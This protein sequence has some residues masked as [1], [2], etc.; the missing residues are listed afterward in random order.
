MEMRTINP[1]T[2]RM[3]ELVERGTEFHG[4]LGPFLISGLRMGLLALRE[5]TSKGHFDLRAVIETGTVPPLSCMIDGVQVATGCTL[6]K[7]NIEVLD[8]GRARA[9]FSRGEKYLVVE[10]RPELVGRFR[11]GEAEAL[12]REA[13][14]MSDGELLKWEL[15]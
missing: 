7:G 12:A 1:G 3:E 15:Q 9:T 5:L 4:H 10:L 14:K 8:L 11:E 2:V 13:L 6:G